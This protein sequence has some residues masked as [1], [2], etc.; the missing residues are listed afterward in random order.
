MFVCGVFVVVVMCVCG[1]G[2]DVFGFG[3]GWLLMCD[4]VMDDD[5]GMT[6][7]AGRAFE[8]VVDGGL[9]DL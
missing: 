8:D 7:G 3:C 1:C 5:V 6:G 2:F 4:G 9:I